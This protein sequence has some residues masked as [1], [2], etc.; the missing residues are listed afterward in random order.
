[1]KKEWKRLRSCGIK[2]CWEEEF[3]CEREHVESEH[4]A[5]GTAAHFVR[6][7]DICVEK[8]YHLPWALLGASTR[9]GRPVK[10]T[11]SK[12]RTAAGRTSEIVMQAAAGVGLGAGASGGLGCTCICVAGQYCRRGKLTPQ[13]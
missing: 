12:T 2:G 13:D 8:N 3:P 9:A 5:A 11:A 10:E 6:V 1:M 7:F 4:H